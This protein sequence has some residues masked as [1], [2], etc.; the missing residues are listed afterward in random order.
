MRS[1]GSAS[2][3]RGYKVHVRSFVIGRSAVVGDA[4]PPLGSGPAPAL[5]LASTRALWTRFEGGNSEEIS[6]WT[7]ALG[8]TP[9]SIDLF[10]SNGPVPGGVFLTGVAG[11]SPTLL[12]GKTFERCLPYPESCATLEA[13]GG[14]SFVTGQYEQPPIDGI[15][16]PALLA[17]AAHDPQSGQISQG[18]VA[19]TP[20]ATPLA[21]DLGDAPRVAENGPVEIY[22]FL[23]RVAFIG[24]V[25]PHGTVRAIA[26]S[27][28]QLAVLVRRADGTEV[29]E[30]HDPRRGTLL[31]TASVPKATTA[32]LSVSAAGTVYRV[33]KKIYLIARGAPKLGWTASGTPIGLSIEGRRIAWAVNLKGRSRIVALTL[34]RSPAP[35]TIQR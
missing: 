19:V 12:Y 14:V 28:P 7:S 35:R 4:F 15:P 5:A 22:R 11:D 26:L 1:P 17:F 33:G 21:T 27:F 30:R 10:L 20:A 25:T 16:A 13:T 34:R 6:L 24:S 8:G 32:A 23:N 31:G 18:M 29:I 9:K 2:P 3:G